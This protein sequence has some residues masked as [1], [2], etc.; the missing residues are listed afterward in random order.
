[1]KLVGERRALAA[2]VF[3]FFFILFLLN[4]IAIGAPD[5]NFMFALAGCYGLAFFALVA[6][7]F[8]AR[9]YAVGVGL[10]GVIVSAVSL[11]Q[12]R[13]DPDLWDL[14]W[15][16]LVFFGSSHLVATVMLWGDAMALPYDGQTKWREKLHMDDNAVQRLGRSVI[17][18]GV[19]L[20]FVLAYAFAPKPESA[21]TALALVAV[22]F[23][24]LGLRAVVR[25]R[26]W[27]VLAIGLAGSIMVTL[28]GADLLMGA[29][30]A[31]VLRPALAGGLLFSAAAP[32]F[33]PMA[34][35]FAASRP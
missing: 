31:W 1:M 27:G 16:T 21:Q 14:V 12:A 32:W 17:R 29:P 11:W 3:A 7:Y 24:A 13:S 9:W 2:I 15:R 33:A 34:R 5:G 4:G 25:A 20:P 28:A 18:A 26:T 8:W 30:D 6:G 23:A 19:G 10:F 35:A 22:A